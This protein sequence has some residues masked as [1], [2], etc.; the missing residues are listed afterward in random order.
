MLR[1]ASDCALHYRNLRVPVL[2]PSRLKMH[3]LGA[4]RAQFQDRPLR[5]LEG[6]HGCQGYFCSVVGLLRAGLGAFAAFAVDV[7]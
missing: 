2:S 3:V 5:A 4:G 7:S 6:H 1:E